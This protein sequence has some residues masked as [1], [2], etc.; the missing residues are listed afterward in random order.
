MLVF[1]IHYMYFGSLLIMLTLPI[2]YP[3]KNTWLVTKLFSYSVF[4]QQILTQNYGR[5]LVDILELLFLP[6][7][8]P[9]WFAYDSAWKT[10]FGENFLIALHVYK[11]RDIF[12]YTCMALYFYFLYLIFFTSCCGI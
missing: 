6:V 1:M 10:S 3:L 4:T 9:I 11:M 8:A 7:Y 12:A 2:L 5:S